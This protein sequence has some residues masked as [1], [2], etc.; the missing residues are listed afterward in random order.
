MEAVR[1]FVPRDGFNLL[2]ES[3]LHCD[4]PAMA[5]ILMRGADIEFGADLGFSPLAM[6]LNSV[7]LSKGDR[8]RLEATKRAVLLLRHGADPEAQSGR[9]RETAADLLPRTEAAGDLYVECHAERQERSDGKCGKEA[10]PEFF[11]PCRSGRKYARCCQKRGIVYHETLSNTYEQQ[12]FTMPPAAMDT[13]QQYLAMRDAQIGGDPNALLFPEVRDEHGRPVD[14][15][16]EAKAAVLEPLRQAGL[17]DPVFHYAADKMDFEVNTAVD[18]YTALGTDARPA[19]EIERAAK[20][21]ADGGPLFRRCAAC[22]SYEETH[23]QYKACSACKAVRYC[24]TDCQA[25]H[26][27]AGHKR[28]CKTR[29]PKAVSRS[30]MAYSLAGEA[31]A[32]GISG[33]ALAAYV[34]Q[35]LARMEREA[36]L[37]G[38]A[39]IQGRSVPGGGPDAF[40]FGALAVLVACCLHFSSLSAVFVLVAGA[41]VEG[42]VFPFNLGRLGNAF[43][44]WL[45]IDPPEIFFFAFLPPLLLD[46]ALSIDY[47]LFKKVAVQVM[48]FAFLVVLLSAL[49]TTPVL[50]YG[51]GLAARGWRWQ[52]GA[53]FSAMLASTDALAITAVLRRAG[54]PESL[55]TLMEGESLLNDASGIVLFELFHRLVQQLGEDGSSSRGS[56]GSS[57]SAPTSPLAVLP[58]LGAEIAQLAAG[59]VAVGLAAGWLTRRLLRLLR[60]FGA[61]ASQE[62]A[63]IVAVGY[64]AF[65]LANAP[66]RVSGVI[67]VVVFGL[68]GN[69]TSHFELASSR[70]MHDSAAVQ[71]TLSFALNGMVFFF[72][73]ASAVNFMIRAVEGLGDYGFAFALFPA[74]YIALF[75]IR[76]LCILLFNPVFALLGSQ[77]LP[78]RAVPFATW[79]GLRGA[80]SLIMCQVVVTDESVVGRS[81]LVA[82]Q[83]GLWTSLFVLCTLLINAPTIPAV[84]R[85]TG[86]TEVSP[87]KLSIREK[88]KRALLRYTAAAVKDLRDDPD[89]MLRGVDWGKVARFV[90]LSDELQLFEKPSSPAGGTHGGSAAVEVRAQGAGHTVLT[91]DAGGA[92]QQEGAQP[93]PAA[94][95]PGAAAAAG[96]V[97]PAALQQDE[98]FEA[99]GW[100]APSFSAKGSARSRRDEALADLGRVSARPPLGHSSRRLLGASFATLSHKWEPRFAGAAGAASAAGQA[101]DGEPGAAASPEASKPR[102]AG[103]KSAPLMHTIVEVGT[104]SEEE[105]GSDG[106]GW[107][108]AGSDF[109]HT[110][111]RQ[112]LLQQLGSAAVPSSPRTM[113]GLVRGRLLPAAADRQAVMQ[114]TR[115]QQQSQ[116]RQSQRQRVPAGGSGSGMSGPAGAGGS[117]GVG[118]GQW[119]EEVLAEARVRLVA[120]L[121]RY[122]HAKRGEGLLSTKGLRILDY[123]CDRAA[124]CAYQPLDIWS[125]AEREAVGRYMIRALAW[126]FF[127]VKRLTGRLPRWM[128]WLLMPPLRWLSGVIGG[129]LSTTMLAACEVAVELW[130]GLTWSPQAQWLRESEKAGRLQAEIGAECGR[131]QRFIID[132]E[133]E[134]PERF[135]AIQSYRAAMAILRQQSAFID[136]LFASGIVNEVE[137]G[138]MQEPVELR[139]RRLEIQ[140]PVWRAPSVRE[141]LRGLPFLQQVPEPLFDALLDR[142]QLIEF[143]RGEVI[144]APPQAPN[145]AGDGLHIVIYGLVRHSFTDR[146]GRAR[147]YFLGSGGVLGPLCALT[148][149]PMPGSGPAIA[150]ANALHKGPV[151][152]HIPQSVMRRVRQRAAAGDHDFAQ[153]ALDLFRV[154]G[155]YVLERMKGEV[156]SAVAGEHRRAAVERARRAAIRHA[157]AASAAAAAVTQGGTR[158]KPPVVPATEAAGQAA[159]LDG[160]A[161][162]GG[163]AAAEGLGGGLG[164]R[165]HSR[166]RFDLPEPQIVEA[167]Q[168][169][170]ALPLP[171]TPFDAAAGAPSSGLG[172]GGVG[173]ESQT[174]GRLP[175]VQYVPLS[176]A[177]VLQRLD[178]QKLWHASQALARHVLAELRLQLRDAELLQLAPRQQWRQRS[179]VLLMRGALHSMPS[180]GG[181]SSSTASSGGGGERCSPEL[182]QAPAVLPWLAPHL[183]PPAGGGRTLAAGS[184][185]ALLLVCP[186]EPASPSSLSSRSS[187]GS[188]SELG[189]SPFADASR[190]PPERGGQEGRAADG[191]AAAPAEAAPGRLPPSGRPLHRVKSRSL[192]GPPALGVEAAGP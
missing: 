85:W 104:S 54:G 144:W 184:G 187:A 108:G 46:S 78:L 16:K 50:L 124:D 20:I 66:L 37:S 70:H 75:L 145:K 64:L 74:I 34:Q 112:P 175:G 189:P 15:F 119:S 88:A 135:Q 122:F 121:K 77:P 172:S 43:T 98:L 161:D 8:A 29:P 125:V 163:R 9:T 130:L 97:G 155:L 157:A 83:L 31:V 58:L 173:Q 47:F 69:S 99:A 4:V 151:V 82:A 182:L 162:A 95:R 65:Y 63:T 27:K 35:M 103:A 123:A 167:E 109:G 170:G 84:L 177:E 92:L 72:A 180:S 154:A 19:L 171:Q 94:R 100:A 192:P 11:C 80:I 87:V 102:L 18:E 28:V 191:G 73:G 24:G 39:S 55:V 159:A 138:A 134:A 183:G 132:R 133:I 113:H 127:R 140:G 149:H 76:G 128:R 166:V 164:I 129:V 71:G 179:H 139:A 116:Q 114:T 136:E 38:W 117:A 22:G 1:P 150:E 188:M 49:I 120:G 33:P 93:G 42:V 51:L 2:Q 6:A 137:R 40:L 91:P 26:W 67:A 181:G 3:A 23:G 30:Q 126:L 153:L 57:G 96:G 17:L 178:Q 176:E 10:D 62:V 86:L 56:S 174:S 32:V 148:G 44:L 79:G 160:E 21:A 158:S 146:A 143:S 89:E 48:F 7:T 190:S 115:Q 156:L 107:G 13:F 68:Y 90:D 52:H 131:V 25:A 165:R 186:E 81:P 147:E 41:L 101:A 60:W 14:V 185:G 61:S 118:P 5:Q 152:F 141:V 36:L 169:G 105:S 142:G 59:G 53:L 168:A 12:M 110:A 106:E 111:E 45:G